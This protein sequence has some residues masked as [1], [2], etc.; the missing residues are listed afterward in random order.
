[1]ALVAFLTGERGVG[2]DRMNRNPMR[3]ATAALALH[4]RCAA[5]LS[6]Y[7]EVCLQPR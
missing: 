1:M 7:R 6:D 5:P 2:K 4:L 3:E